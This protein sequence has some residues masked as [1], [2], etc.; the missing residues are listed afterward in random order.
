MCET[1]RDLDQKIFRYSEFLKQ[2]LDPL[3]SERSKEANREMQQQHKA[4]LH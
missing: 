2:G 4:A 3:T 1:C